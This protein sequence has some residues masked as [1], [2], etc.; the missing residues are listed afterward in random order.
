MSLGL[1]RYNSRV[2]ALFLL[3]ASPNCS[4]TTAIKYKNQLEYEGFLGVADAHGQLLQLERPDEFVFVGDEKV[5]GVPER[6]KSRHKEIF[7]K[8]LENNSTVSNPVYKRCMKVVEELVPVCS[9][10]YDMNRN[11]KIQE[12][13]HMPVESIDTCTPECKLNMK[14]HSFQGKRKYIPVGFCCCTTTNCNENADRII[15]EARVNRI[16]FGESTHPLTGHGSANPDGE[17]LNWP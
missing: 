6:E 13:F 8:C 12:C 3:F 15:D 5:E 17:S 4:A 9:L 16:D 10:T 1:I 11:E 2:I 14:I 7:L